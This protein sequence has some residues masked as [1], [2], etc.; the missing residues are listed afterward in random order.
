MQNSSEDVMGEPCIGSY[1][2]RKWHADLL[3]TLEHEVA[4]LRKAPKGE[5]AK[6]SRDRKNERVFARIKQLACLSFQGAVHAHK[7]ALL[8]SWKDVVARNTARRNK[9]TDE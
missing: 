1:Y 5:S 6:A 4:T 8:V 3:D 9:K 7:S 2:W